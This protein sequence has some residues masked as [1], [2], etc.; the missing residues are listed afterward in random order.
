MSKQAPPTPPRYRDWLSYLFDREA[1]D[2]AWYQT[3]DVL[4]FEGEPAEIAELFVHTM[5][6][7]GR[8]L[9]GFSDRQAAEGLQF[10]T[11]PS[12][13]DVVFQLTRKPLS[14]DAREAVILSIETLYSDCFTPRCAPVLGHLDEPGANPLNR[15]CYMLWDVS[16][17]LS[18]TPRAV[19]QVIEAG[20]TSP[21]PACQE[22]ALHGL[23]HF[24]ASEGRDETAN[25]IASYLR[26][27]RPTA[28]LRAYAERA[29]RGAI[30]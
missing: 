10:L 13:G 30:P 6:N 18:G 14:K 28:K 25:M 21:N 9:A 8:D 11:N 15:V 23:G 22:S 12:C 24:P 5:R 4:P 2:R 16:P 17:L 7:C 26:T 27:Q 3:A 1:T 29:A 20:L 19:L